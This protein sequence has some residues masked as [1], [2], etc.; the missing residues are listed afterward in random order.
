VKEIRAAQLMIERGFAIARINWL[1][2]PRGISQVMT[3][4]YMAPEPCPTAADAKLRT[5]VFTLHGINSHLS[6]TMAFP[7]ALRCVHLLQRCTCYRSHKHELVG[8]SLRPYFLH[9]HFLPFPL[10]W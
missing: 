2:H 9:L 7:P 1:K 6:M 4:S 8:I 3:R 10:Y 5:A